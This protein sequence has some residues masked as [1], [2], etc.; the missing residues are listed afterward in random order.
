[1]LYSGYWIRSSAVSRLVI[2]RFSDSPTRRFSSSF[3]VCLQ[4]L[5]PFPRFPNSPSLPSAIW[6]SHLLTFSASEVLCRPSSVICR[7][8]FSARAPRFPYRWELCLVLCCWKYFSRFIRPVNALLINN[9]LP[10]F[11]GQEEL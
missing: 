6:S 5:A 3:V 9:K 1:M 7:L 8:G 11:V 4:A 10:S 2:L